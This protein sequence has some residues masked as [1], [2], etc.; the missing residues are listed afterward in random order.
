MISRDPSIKLQ[1]GNEDVKKCSFL[2]KQLILSAIDLIDHTSESGGYLVYST[3][4]ISVEENEVS[5]RCVA[6]L[7]L[8]RRCLRWVGFHRKW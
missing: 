2:Q 5:L 4:S 1:K 3:C 6:C 7:L 8:S